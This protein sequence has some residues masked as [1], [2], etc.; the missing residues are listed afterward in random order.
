[1][2]EAEKRAASVDA[3]AEVDL[4]VPT[5]PNEPSAGQRGF[6]R[7]EVAGDIGDKD[8]T[9]AGAGLASAAPPVIIEYGCAPESKLGQVK[10]KCKIIRITK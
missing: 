9:S 6:V 1:M 2:A 3:E 10:N 7:G 8:S 4:L 5:V